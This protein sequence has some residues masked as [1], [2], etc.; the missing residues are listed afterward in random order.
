[1]VLHQHGFS[2]LSALGNVEARRALA[3]DASFDA[4]LIGWSTTYEERRAIVGWLK[5]RWPTIPVIAIHDSFQR[6]IPGADFTSAHDTPD[7]WISAVKTATQ[8]IGGPGASE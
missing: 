8:Q 4:F 3:S 5:Q 6:P 1:L 7:E 2:V